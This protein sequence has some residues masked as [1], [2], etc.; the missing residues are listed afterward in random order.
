MDF[1]HYTENMPR[2]V[3]I[4]AAHAPSISRDLNRNV[5]AGVT[6]HQYPN[7]VKVRVYP[8][9][10]GPEVAKYL[11]SKGY[12]YTSKLVTRHGEAMT[13]AHRAN[14]DLTLVTEFIITSR[15]P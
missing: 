12:K 5:K 8:S 7:G 6:V 15:K 11:M 14:P 3:K 9:K 1:A 13:A 4:T 10:N 2:P